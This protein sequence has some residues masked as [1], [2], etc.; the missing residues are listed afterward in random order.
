MHRL[1]KDGGWKDSGRRNHRFI[2]VNLTHLINLAWQTATGSGL[3]DYMMGLTNSL[4]YKTS[5]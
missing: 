4:T 3:Y 2:P 5:V 1:L